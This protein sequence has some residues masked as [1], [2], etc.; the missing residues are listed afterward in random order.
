MLCTIFWQHPEH[1]TLITKERQAAYH[2][3]PVSQP[4]PGDLDGILPGHEDKC[5]LF[6]SLTHLPV[7][8]VT[9]PMAHLIGDSLG[10]GT[11]HRGPEGPCLFIPDIQCLAVR[12]LDRIVVPGSKAVLA[13]IAA[14]GITC[15]AFT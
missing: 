7:M 11:G 1:Q 13:A 4:Q 6:Q 14:P 2:R 15:P 10:H 3:S 12:I 8:A 9:K 5:V